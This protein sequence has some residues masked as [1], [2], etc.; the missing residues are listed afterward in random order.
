[1]ILNDGLTLLAIVV[2]YHVGYYR[3]RN[4][5]TSREILRLVT[6]FFL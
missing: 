4:H 5:H 6:V 3:G 2:I 1:M